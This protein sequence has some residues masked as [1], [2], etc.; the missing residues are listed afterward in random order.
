MPDNPLSDVG[1]SREAEYFRKR[2]QELIEKM[3]RAAAAETTRRELSASTGLQDPEVIAELEALGFSPDTVCLLPLV[4]LLEIAWAE[5][6]VSD[7][8]RV[9][10]TQ[11]ARSRGIADGSAAGR[12][13]SEWLTTRPSADMFASATRLVRVMLAAA[14]SEA[15]MT[16]DDLVKY[17]ETIAAASGGIFGLNRISA[18]ERALLQRIAAELKRQ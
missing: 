11:L 18:E 4:P 9:L 8:E 12:Q 7:A 10:V 17:S 14:G 13:L 1:Y 15:A 5:G 2:D 6:G 16:A 3:R